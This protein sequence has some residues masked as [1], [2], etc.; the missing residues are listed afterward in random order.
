M[1]GKKSAAVL[2]LEAQLTALDDLHDKAVKQHSFTAA[3]KAKAAAGEVRLRL[4]RIEAEEQLTRA[5]SPLRR[6]Q[7]LR[8]LAVQDGSWIA[9]AKLAEEEERLRAEEAAAREAK[10]DRQADGMSDA[11]IVEELVSAIRDLPAPLQEQIRQAIREAAPKRLPTA[12]AAEA[13][14]EDS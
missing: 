6:V 10:E 4:R 9:A 5:K 2:E 8:G 13:E 1:A 11:E 14:D 3:I 7:I 12:P